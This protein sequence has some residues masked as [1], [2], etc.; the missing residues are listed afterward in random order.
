[1]N[2]LI[3]FWTTPFGAP[4]FHLFRNEDY[5]P[6]FEEALARHADEIAAIRDNA[7]RPSFGNTIAAM[8]RSGRALAQVAAVF[9]NLSGSDTNEEF[10]AIE[11]EMTPLLARHDSAILL[12]G[13]LFARID[14]LHSER[15][16]LGLDDEELRVLDRYHARFRRAGAGLD[17]EAKRRLAEISERLASLG[18]D[19]GQNVLADERAYTL[20]L[21]GEEDLAGLPGFLR[22]GAAEA[23]RARG[24]EGRHVIT[25]SRS[26]IEPFLQFSQRRDL[27]EKAFRAWISRG[28]NGGEHDNRAIVAEMVALRAERARLLGF[29]SFAH[30]RLD[31]AMA[32]TPEAVLGLLTRVWSPAKRRAAEEK[33]AL[34]DLAAEGGDNVALAPWDWRFY[35]ERLRLRRFD[36]DEGSI[37]PYL[38]LDAMIEA[39]FDTA[40]RLFGVTFRHAP[41][42]PVYH[43]DVR[44]WEVLDRDGGHLGLF[45]GDYFA[46][47]SKRSGAWMSTFRDQEAVDVPV[48]PIVVNV[49]NFTKPPEGQPALLSMDDARTLFHE[50]GHGLHGLLSNVRFPLISGTSVARDFV[51]L[52]SQ[53]F[54]H[55]LEQKETL[56]RFA[57]HYE[58]GEPMPDAVI[59][60]VLAARRFNQGFATVEYTSSA[61]VDLEFHL[62]GEGT[63]VDPLA[64]EAEV[65]ARIGMPDAIVMRHRT[66]HFAHVF[67]G[68][69]YSAGY[70]SYLWSEVLDADAFAAFQETGDIFDPQTAGRLHDFIYS[71]GGSRDPGE[72]YRLFRGR[73]P[74]PE[75]LLAKRGLAEVVVTGEA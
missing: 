8:E 35:A 32:K 36:L 56:A 73:L 54:E 58:T 6:A 63:D 48:R 2:P 64:F 20:V 29:A 19:F 28:E 37:K 72:A 14:A 33:A 49:M 1:M 43:P 68:E 61:L 22:D 65:L 21:D 16:G 23:A 39:A 30:F 57:R 11:R 31:D 53:L 27:R 18:T 3:S 9:F 44:A 13:A 55:W 66:P 26:S 46:R 4:P 25:L 75:A 45:Y 40:T 51:E 34:E 12:D 70:Y 47:P 74:T 10:E 24:F 69:G 59:D 42:A 38:Q 17:G 7:E 5:R 50:F 60:R 15:D 52:P 67:S 71:A 62:L 41:E